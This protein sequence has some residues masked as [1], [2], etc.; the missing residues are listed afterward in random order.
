MGRA[1]LPH[2]PGSCLPELLPALQPSTRPPAS[3]QDLRPLPEGQLSPEHTAPC[4]VRGP[5]AHTAPRSP[6]WSVT[7]SK[8][9][10]PITVPVP[11]PP[12]P[13]PTPPLFPGPGSQHPPWQSLRGPAPLSAPQP[14]G[15]E[16]FPPPNPRT[17]RSGHRG[18]GMSGPGAGP[19]PAWEA[20]GAGTAT[21]TPMGCSGPRGRADP[22]ADTWPCP[23]RVAGPAPPHGLP[24]ARLK[25]M[26][27]SLAALQDLLPES[28]AGCGDP[29][30]PG[31]RHV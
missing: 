25:E 10:G 28:S 4:P 27:A 1:K 23:P 14:P 6:L 29:Q 31:C 8:S 17:S 7:K 18:D 15:H 3:R 5:G 11:S 12:Q 13:H 24:L 21:T 2:G 19:G 30:G 26:P 16:L 22:R 9:R 20:G